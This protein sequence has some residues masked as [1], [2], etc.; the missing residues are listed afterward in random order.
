MIE[1]KK[2][3]FVFCFLVLNISCSK[4]EVNV[5]YSTELIMDKFL[6]DHFP[7][8][9]CTQEYTIRTNTN[10]ERNN[11]AIFLKY[12]NCLQSP[13]SLVSELINRSFVQYKLNENCSLVIN[14]TETNE[15]LLDSGRVEE[16]I[17]FDSLECNYSEKIPIPNINMYFENSPSDYDIYIFE[18]KKGEYSKFYKF[19]YNILMPSYWNHGY[20]KG[21]AFSKATNE[22]IYWG[23]MW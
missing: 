16:P 14:S 21:V 10:E 12:T 19:S 23:C 4:K 9:I 6:Y 18:A 17:D 7:V 20:S 11:V 13:D 3:L 2:I 15:S 5:E 22:I 8:K 1:S